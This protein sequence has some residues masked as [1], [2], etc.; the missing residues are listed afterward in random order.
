MDPTN[1]HSDLISELLIFQKWRD[2][3]SRIRLRL[4]GDSLS[5][6]AWACV[7][8]SSPSRVVF[9]LRDSVGVFAFNP[10]S[11]NLRYQDTREAD[12]SVKAGVESK[13]VCGVSAQVDGFDLL[14]W[15]WRDDVD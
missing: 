14:M 6:E 11:S 3:V 8:E 4:V 2:S 7:T 5:F 1:A 13:A 9:A 15:E 12:E 10:S